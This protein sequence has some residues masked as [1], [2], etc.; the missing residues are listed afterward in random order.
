MSLLVDTWQTKDGEVWFQ[1]FMPHEPVTVELKN[2]ELEGRSISLAKKGTG[3][4]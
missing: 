2:A 4:L 1:D 3:D